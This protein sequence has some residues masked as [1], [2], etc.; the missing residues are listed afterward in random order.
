[1]LVVLE[2]IAPK[3]VVDFMV[4]IRRVVVPGGSFLLTKPPPWA[5]RILRFIVGIGLISSTEFDEH[6]CFYNLG[7]ITD[8]LVKTGFDRGKIRVGHFEIFVKNRAYADK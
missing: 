3:R 4:D 5:D 2:H 6:K 1:M 7:A 8:C